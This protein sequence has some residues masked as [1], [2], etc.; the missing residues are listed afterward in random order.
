MNLILEPFKFGIVLN[1]PD[2][3]YGP[4]GT[5]GVVIADFKKLKEKK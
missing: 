4:D 1:S 2:Y 5:V 3:G